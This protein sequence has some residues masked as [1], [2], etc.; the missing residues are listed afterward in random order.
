MNWITASA[1]GGQDTS[2]RGTA[3]EV[4]G[5]LGYQIFASSRINLRLFTQF[6]SVPPDPWSQAL[7]QIRGQYTQATNVTRTS[8][9]LSIGYY[10]PEDRTFLKRAFFPY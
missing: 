6:E 5:E 7:T 4:F 3:L 9:G 8:A 10:F 1:N 2:S